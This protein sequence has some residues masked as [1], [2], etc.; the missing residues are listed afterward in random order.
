MPQPPHPERPGDLTPQEKLAAMV[1][2]AF[3]DHART[4]TD[5]DTAEAFLITLGLMRK[6]LDGARAQDLID[7]AAH[8]DLTGM[9]DGMQAAPGLLT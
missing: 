1:E 6:V 9:L 4:L 2:R 5:P 3:A 7:E 8:R